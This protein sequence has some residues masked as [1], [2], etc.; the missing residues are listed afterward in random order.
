MI[1]SFLRSLEER[2]R[3][4]KGVLFSSYYDQLNTY[5]G[6]AALLIAHF[7]HRLFGLG[8]SNKQEI[9][10]RFDA[11]RLNKFEVKVLDTLNPPP[12]EILVVSAA[13]DFWLLEPALSAALR[14]TQNPVAQ[15]NLVIPANSRNL[16][17]RLESILT[18]INILAEENL[19]PPSLLARLRQTFAERS[20][21][22]LQQ[23]LTLKFVELSKSPGVLTLDADTLLIEPETWLDNNGAQ[24]LHVSSEYIPA[25]YRFLAE[26]GIGS[27]KPDTTH[28]THHMMMQP[29]ILR[30]ILSKH[31]L[32]NSEDVLE[33]AI[34]FHETYGQVEF[35]LEFEL[36]AQG[37]K[38]FHP[39]LIEF[40]KFANKTIRIKNPS[41]SSEV[42]FLL[43]KLR[44]TF[45][46]VSA[47]SYY[48]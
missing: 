10:R 40:R 15:I 37:M 44:G 27:L 38:E 5:P 26:L 25:Y 13:K 31:G 12:I 19:I 46:S 48:Q 23:Y 32:H 39:N 6:R 2:N 11:T 1:K 14:A 22:I 34:E 36:Y 16:L 7:L 47:H 17:P 3:F 20:G 41:S 24:L 30:E 21:W 9:A 43:R 33:R 28:V 18:P 35:C 29:E 4:L 42:N 45:R 8:S